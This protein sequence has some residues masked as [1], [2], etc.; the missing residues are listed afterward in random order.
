MSKNHAHSFPLHRTSISNPSLLTAVPNF[1]GQY[2]FDG[3]KKSYLYSNELLPKR[4]TGFLPISL[5]AMISTPVTILNGLDNR[6]APIRTAA[7]ERSTPHI[8]PHSK[9]CLTTVLLYAGFPPHLIERPLN[10][11]TSLIVCGNRCNV[12]DPPAKRSQPPFCTLFAEFQHN[13]FRKNAC[14]SFGWIWHE[15]GSG[16]ALTGAF[17]S[18]S[19][20]GKG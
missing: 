14:T 10:K 6:S 4:T 15:A 20:R 5:C 2:F 8:T 13:C 1:R 3:I 9:N 16:R 17:G 12:G 19:A 7:K 11:F 18:M